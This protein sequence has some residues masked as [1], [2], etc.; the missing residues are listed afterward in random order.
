MY[1]SKIVLK[2]IR[3][4]GELS[5]DCR[6]KQTLILGKNG[7]GKTT[8]LRS[9][10]LG[11]CQGSDAYTLLVEPR[12]DF[13]KAGQLQAEIEF[14]ANDALPS[15]RASTSKGH[16]MPSA[17]VAAAS[18]AS[19]RRKMMISKQADGYE[20]TSQQIPS[21]VLE[22]IWPGGLFVWGIGA[23]R[24]AVG[25]ESK[26]EYRLKDAVYSLFNYHQALLEPE[27][28]LRRL[29]DYMGTQKY[30]AIL[31]RLKQG[32]GLA[33]DDEIL[34]P[35][36]GGVVL[37][38]PSLGQQIPLEAWADGYRLTFN[39][40]IDLYGW[41][42]Q[43][44]SIGSDGH[45]RGVVLVDELEQHLHPSLQTEILPRLAQL[46]PH[47]QLF[48]TTH[49]PLVAL[50]ASPDS[51]VVLQRDGNEIVKEEAVPDFNGY[52]AEDMLV[53]Q[54]LFNTPNVY[55]PNIN[56]QLAEYHQLAEIPSEQRSPHQSARLR[57]LARILRSQQLPEVRQPT[58]D[59]ELKQ[60][61]QK[62]G[63]KN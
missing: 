43:A 21:E 2:N 19:V 63:I 54:R 59:P 15:E 39:W 44:D 1:I 61:L 56:R 47:I 34:L 6:S 48:A 4:I 5:I 8:L 41:A 57:T 62:Y 46:M 40:L 50:G 11:L 33:D 28:T 29:R 13:L 23:G 17:R 49:S 58:V 60:I 24:S 14:E 22:E 52:S 31:G 35:K 53:D 37:S 12:G 7:T 3:G 30:A 38:F 32:L 26:R 10:A 36:G 55:S 27:L 20:I 51:V 45:I 16:D 42:M 9:I 25:S 18:F